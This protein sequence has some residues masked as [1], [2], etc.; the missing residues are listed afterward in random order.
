VFIEVPVDLLYPEATVRGNFIK[1]AGVEN[2]KTLGARALR[3]YLDAH[4]QR[5]FHWPTTPKMSDLVHPPKMNL[6][7]VG[8]LVRR[9]ARRDG[10][11]R[12]AI[13]EIASMLRRA[14]RPVL[15]IGSQTMS[16]LAD[17]TSLAQ[18]VRSL[19]IP[20]YLGGMARG[21]LGRQDA[22]QY[23]HARGKALKEADLVVVAGFPFDFRM[24]YGR[25]FGKAKVVAANLSVD[26][27]L[28][29]RTPEVALQLHP[30]RFLESLAKIAA[31]N[32]S[33]R[34][35]RAPWFDALAAREAARD[36]EIQAQAGVAGELVNPMQFFLRMEALMDDDATLVADGGDFVATASYILRPR[37]PQRW[38]DPGVF[39]TLGVGG[40]FAV[41]AAALR[42]GQE[43]WILYG[44]GSSAYT[45]AEFDTF[46]RHGLAPIA[47]IGN[48]ACWAQIAR[49]Q[50]EMLGDD[51]GT[52]LAR[53]AY[54]DVA[55]GY[56][57]VGLL[58]DDPAKI[59]ETL[60]E[61]KAIARSGR[62]VCLNVHIARSDFRKGSISI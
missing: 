7:H 41:A 40:G 60:R 48:D 18:A 15:V 61:A 32:A 47:V 20:T 42:R 27:L 23:R 3:L 54:H 38:L 16:G 14:E 36:A 57:G 10:E 46:A 37:A 58:L 52:V 17:A 6:P 56:G 49:E 30:A 59:D 21:L 9:V 39:G 4:L 43:T 26:E 29:N 62:P 19:G 24:G 55:E 12:G 51:V 35:R 13:N 34:S 5:Q 53:T 31:S 11:Q 33:E 45:L 25:G 22:L 1:E 50:V 2:P 8:E 44:D 28:K